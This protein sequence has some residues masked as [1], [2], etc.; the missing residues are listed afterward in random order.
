MF[1]IFIFYEAVLQVYWRNM[2]D[3]VNIRSGLLC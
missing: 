3:T 1:I 2:L